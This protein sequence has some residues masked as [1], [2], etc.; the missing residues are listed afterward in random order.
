MQTN[1]TST[2]ARKSCLFFAKLS[3]ENLLKAN[4]Y[5]SFKSYSTSSQLLKGNTHVSLKHMSALTICMCYKCEWIFLHYLTKH[6]ILCHRVVIYQHITTTTH[7]Y[8]KQDHNTKNK[9]F[10]IFGCG[11]YLKRI[12]KV[13][14]IIY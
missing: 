13:N 12:E 7:P 4:I 14:K 8:S 11:E 6:R 3:C 2:T 1:N 5:M 9:I 10:S